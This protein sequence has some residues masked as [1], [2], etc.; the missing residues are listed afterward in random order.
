[1]LGLPSTHPPRPSSTSYPLPRR[2]QGCEDELLALPETKLLEKEGS[3]CEALL[4][5]NKT[6]DLSR[7]YRL[8]SRVGTGLTPIGAIVRKHITEVGMALV[9]KQEDGGGDGGAAS[10]A[11][12]AASS[13]DMNPYIQELLD[14]HDKYQELVRECFGQNAIFQKAMK[15]AFEIFVNKDIHKMTTAEMLSNFCDNLLKKSGERLDDQQLDDKLEKVVRLFSYLTDKDIFAEF[16][17]KQLAKRLL[18]QRSA[19]DDAERSMIAKLKLKCGAQF[20]SKL[21]GMVT[22]MNLSAD[23]QSAF[24]EWMQEKNVHLDTE[25]TVQ[26]L[27]TGFWPTYKSDELNL[28]SEMVQCVQ[29]F[30]EYYDGRTSHRRL[31]WVHSLGSAQVLSTF[32]PGGKEKKHDLM[33]S[34]YQVWEGPPAPGR[35]QAVAHPG[36]PPTAGVH[37]RPLQ[38]PG[39]VHLRRDPKGPQPAHGGAQ[40]LRTVAL[41]GQVQNPREGACLKRDQR[42]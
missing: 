7:M 30:K 15:E 21:E 11:V 40:A 27:T 6:E 4:R 31:R 33:V 8:F 29:A 13:P 14:V 41:R 18:L 37:P 19:S 24:S 20:T 25:L 9:R 22:D 36:L 35:V 12:Q 17:K 2:V 38:Q 32:M 42:K 34:T 10:S 16:Y 23:I 28:P 1:M 26:V 5:D 39:A 3:G